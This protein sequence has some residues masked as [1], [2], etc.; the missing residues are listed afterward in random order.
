MSLHLPKIDAP[1]TCKF[2]NYYYLISTKARAS[3]I[4][5]SKN[6]IGFFSN[7]SRYIR[8]KEK[9]EIIPEYFI[10]IT[11]NPGD[12]S[13]IVVQSKS[14]LNALI[15]P[16]KPKIPHKKNIYYRSSDR[17]KFITN[18]D[19]LK[20][21]SEGTLNL[22]SFDSNSRNQYERDYQPFYNQGNEFFTL[23]K[24]SKYSKMMEEVDQYN[25]DYKKKIKSNQ[26]PRIS[27]KLNKNKHMATPTS[28]VPKTMNTINNITLSEPKQKKPKTDRH[29][30][31]D[32]IKQKLLPSIK[33]EVNQFEESDNENKIIRHKKSKVNFI[34]PSH[35]D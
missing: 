34:P 14:K 8:D 7:L 29:K 1:L 2:F 31:K 20:I 4:M 23:N 33:Q 25:I 11:H 19:H 6:Q 27:L 3:R 28:K 9:E 18:V 30:L 21:R 26:S 32:I 24:E 35:R 17:L 5:K 12:E 13:V 16:E 10:N 22:Q 15:T